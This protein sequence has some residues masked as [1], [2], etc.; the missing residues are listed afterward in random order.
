MELR[1]PAPQALT[2]RA[3]VWYASRI[4]ELLGCPNPLCPSHVGR[5]PAKGPRLCEWFECDGRI[6]AAVKCGD[7]PEQSAI[8]AA[9][10]HPHLPPPR[11]ALRDKAVADWNKPTPRNADMR[12]HR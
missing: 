6:A 8:Y 2:T 9:N 5:Q 1:N 10:V 11:G 3:K 7:C 12:S 4:M